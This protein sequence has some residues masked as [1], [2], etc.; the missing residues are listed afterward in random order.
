VGSRSN[1]T[2]SLATSPGL[3][4]TCNEWQQICSG[5]IIKLQWF[6]GTFDYKTA[7]SVHH[8]VEKLAGSLMGGSMGKFFSH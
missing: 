2:H 8:T 6:V 5:Y 7:K 1:V 4:N 3:Q